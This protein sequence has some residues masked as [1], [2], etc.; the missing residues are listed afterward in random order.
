M[1]RAELPLRAQPEVRFA[2]ETQALAREWRTRFALED[3]TAA[4]T[5]PATEESQ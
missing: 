1:R 4:A 5:R 3:D 2:A